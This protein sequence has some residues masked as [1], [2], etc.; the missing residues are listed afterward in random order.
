MWSTCIKFEERTG[1]KPYC[2][3]AATLDEIL[4]IVDDAFDKW[5]VHHASIFADGKFIRCYFMAPYKIKVARMLARAR[6]STVHH[7]W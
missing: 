7:V 4:K 3:K 6:H 5:D 2:R 1:W